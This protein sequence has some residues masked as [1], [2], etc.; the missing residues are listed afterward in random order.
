MLKKLLNYSI[1]TA[2]YIA[3]VAGFVCLMILLEVVFNI[4]LGH[5]S[6]YAIL[7]IG[8]LTASA[9]KNPIQK[10]FKVDNRTLARINKQKLDTKYP[11]MTDVLPFNQLEQ[12]DILLLEGGEK[13]IYDKK[14]PFSKKYTVWKKGEMHILQ[15]FSA[16]ELT[17]LTL[18]VS[19]KFGVKWKR[20]ARGVEA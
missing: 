13:Y 11:I 1:V 12:G 2:L 16:Q 18:E 15:E 6:K 10:F 5:I 4:R 20:D 7:I 3:V 14:Y 8:I 19:C 17:E 9:L